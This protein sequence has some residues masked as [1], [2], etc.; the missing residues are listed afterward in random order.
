MSRTNKDLPYE[1]RAAREGVLVHDH[2]ESGA[3]SIYTRSAANDVRARASAHR[4]SG[5]CPRYTWI[6]ECRHDHRFEKFQRRIDHERAGGRPDGVAIVATEMLDAGYFPNCR[7]AKTHM[8]DLREVD[9]G[10]RPG[11]DREAYKIG[12]VWAWRLYYGSPDELNG[13]IYRK[14]KNARFVPDAE[15][16]TCEENVYPR[17]Y[18]EFTKDNTRC[19]C[20]YCVGDRYAEPRARVRDRLRGYLK[21]YNTTGE[22]DF[23][24]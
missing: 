16:K 19:R 14:I 24:F 6:V 15:C 17:C 10:L 20:E 5:E 8:V 23:E 9:L 1:V 3:C 2:S 13:T 18:Y 11:E 7:A 21:E 4:K 12:G 22:V